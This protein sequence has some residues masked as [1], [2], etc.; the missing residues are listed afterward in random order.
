MSTFTTPFTAATQVQR[1]RRAIVARIGLWAVRIA[2]AMQFAGGGILKLTGNPTMVTMFDD[3]GAGQWLRLVVGAGELAGAIGVLV[4]R[5]SR[6][7]G[8]GL[9]GLM[10]GAALTNVV[11]L[12]VSPAIPLVLLALAAFVALVRPQAGGSR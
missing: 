9:V 12:H 1:P 3:I 4:P 5:L 8:T 7:A 2:L 10:V 6:I 11:A